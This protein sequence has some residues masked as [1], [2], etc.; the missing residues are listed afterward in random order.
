M[1]PQ[2]PPLNPKGCFILPL[3]PTSL[4]IIPFENKRNHYNNGTHRQACAKPLITRAS[5]YAPF[6]ITHN[7]LPLQAPRSKTHTCSIQQ[8]MDNNTQ[9]LELMGEKYKYTQS[10]PLWEN[11]VCHFPSLGATER[12]RKTERKWK[13]R[14]CYYGD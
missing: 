14:G 2:L 9:T 8:R 1:P 4:L 7:H 3:F 6:A 10:H 12:E 11:L 13:K 5:L